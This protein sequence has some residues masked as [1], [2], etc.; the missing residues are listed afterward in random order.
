MMNG[1]GGGMWFGWLFWLVIIA[2]VVWGV[3]AIVNSNRGQTQ[4]PPLP[5]GNDAMEILKKRYA[6]GEISQEEFEQMKK[7]LMD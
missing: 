6:R 3:I 4:A 2:L 1:M 5:P 7:D